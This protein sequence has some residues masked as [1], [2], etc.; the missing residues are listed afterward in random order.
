MLTVGTSGCAAVGVVTEL[1]NVHATLSIGIVAS[2]I[3]CDGG[4]G[5]FRGL[6]EGNSSG[7]LRVPPDGSNYNRRGPSQHGSKDNSGK[8]GSHLSHRPKQM[9]GK[10]GFS[11]H[12]GCGLLL[13]D[14]TKHAQNPAIDPEFE[15]VG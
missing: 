10:L 6:L 11:G 14:I 15:N 9:L 1:M 5:G 2:Y 13:A 7:N 8:S 4:W 3:P 12:P